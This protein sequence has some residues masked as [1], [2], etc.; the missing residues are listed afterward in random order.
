MATTDVLKEEHAG[1]KTMLRILG[2][3]C[4]RLEA[5]EEVDTEHLEDIVDFLKVFVD[6]CHH[7]KEEDL[8]FP[9][10]E[11]AGI[12]REGGP[13]GVMLAEHEEGRACIGRMVEAI[14]DLHQWGGDGAVRFVA[15]ARRYTALLLNHIDKED[16]VLYPVAEARL[17]P[18]RLAK[19]ADGF[20]EVEET[21]IGHG[22]HEEFHRMIDRLAATYLP[23]RA[24]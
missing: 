10:M 19:L 13:I 8:L 4:N 18:E 11:E 24:A 20:E 14:R 22:K 9:A 21:R 16:N 12:P 5:G 2:E 15:N 17:S 1:I 6:K 23:G 3:V 7:A